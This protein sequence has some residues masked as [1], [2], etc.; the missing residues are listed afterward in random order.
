VPPRTSAVPRPGRLLTSLVVLIVIMLLGIVAGSLFAP[1]SWQH[2][3]KVGLGLDLSSGTTV[4]LRAQSP[5]SAHM[6]SSQFSSAFSTAVTIMN[7]RVNGAGFNG[8]TV[9]PQG[10]NLIVVTVP[11]KNY[12]Q[13]A[14]LVGTTAQL[15]FRQV[16]LVAPNSASEA[17][18][19]PTP[20]PTPSSSPTPKP[21]TSS[22][23][24]ASASPTASTSAFGD[25][26]AGGVSVTA[27]RTAAKPA[28]SPSASPSP[29][30]SP[31]PSPTPAPGALSTTADGSG[32]ASLLTAATKAAFDKVNCADKNWQAQLYGNNANSWDNPKAQIVVCGA[33][34]GGP[35][36][37][38]IALDKAYVTGAEL[39]N[40]GASAQPQTNGDWYVDMTFDSQ[41][42]TANSNQTT[43]MYDSYY[44]TTN[45]QAN[46]VLDYFAIVLDG[47]PEAIP[48]VE[49][50][51]SGTSE[52]RGTFTQSQANQLVDVLNYGALPLTFQQESVESITP[53][54]GSSYLHAGLIA[55]AIGLALVVCYSFF[56]YRG[57]GIVS[58]SSL[59]IAALLSYLSVVLLS[60]YE[61]FALTLAGIAGLI[62]A[63]GITADS[64]VVFFERLRDEV[65]DGRTLRTAVERG[66]VRAR[67]TILVSD[68]VSFI[69]AALLYKLA[70]GDVQDFGFTLG[71][72]TLIDI[73]VVFLFTKP[74]VS[75]L[76]RTEFFGNGH[77]GSG[78]DPARLG[79]QS[80]W[81][82]T[83][84]PASRP[85][86]GAAGG[87]ASQ[88]QARSN[89][90]EA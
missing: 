6:T 83:R 75:L 37:D 88:A 78:L 68:T 44:D 87:A 36:L 80:P 2:R 17:T 70:V 22:S 29:T 40:G 90:K 42:A 69:A 45:S 67:R 50:P 62:V 35:T 65:R 31:S 23:P 25:T 26:G 27:M 41:G 79:V 13:V 84:Q 58:V 20:T 5:A 14:G 57:L 60:D 11:G 54:L 24:K 34:D 10:S 61:G 43:K 59:A 53:Q 30:P 19:S 72:T 38:K 4:T 82:G 64:F 33:F 89:P 74:M 55:A 76:A 7:N 48:Y 46:S 32:E 12:Q 18:P 86:A 39:K 8:A 15:R 49:Q 63:I 66:W 73:I 16:L 56:Y 85:A 28:A 71:L 51:T 47:V 52:I 3:F 77:K 9:V 81:R 21:S 1:A